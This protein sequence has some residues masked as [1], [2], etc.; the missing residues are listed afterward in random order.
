[1]ATTTP[2]ADNFPEEQMKNTPASLLRGLVG[3]NEF[4]LLMVLIVGAILVTL[5]NPRFLSLS[6]IAA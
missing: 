5:R 2:A 1:M 3:T 6:N 4:A